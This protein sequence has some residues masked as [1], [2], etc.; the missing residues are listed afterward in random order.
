MA[1]KMFDFCI[2]NPP[3]QDETLGDNKG[4]APPVYDQF[5]DA[6][7]EISE[8]VELIHPARF[9]FN[10]GSTPKAWNKKMLSDPH[11][12]V[13]FHEQNSA[14]VFPNT[15]IMGGVAVT[16]HDNS[17]N[18]G[19]IEIYTAFDE[20]NSILKKVYHC[21]EFKSF[22]DIVISSYSYHFTKAM[23][24]DYPLAADKLSKGHQYDL[25]SNVLEKLD[26]IFLVEPPEQIEK[27]VA[28]YGRVKNERVFRYILKEYITEVSNLYKW[29]IFVPKANGSGALG[30]VVSTSVI[31][32]PIV[33]QPAVGHT[34]SFISIGS[35]ETENEAIACYKYI[36]SKFAR[37]LLGILK[38]TQ[39]N[40]PEKWKYIP[41]QIF[42]K[43]SDIDWSKSV[44]EIDLQLYRK[45][46]L[47]SEEIDFIETNVK[48]MI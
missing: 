9:L 26:N 47:S 45:Y 39:D 12:K 29:K 28:I 4:F 10:A 37:C 6:A 22:K 25:K 32:Q 2:G 40:P 14:K 11:L 36:C 33:I 34:E 13:L 20:L 31:G 1:K 42:T 3:Y 35:F 41:L 15:D 43:N 21:K 27:Y 16:Y 17:K 48:E 7:Y 30:E 46:G 23:H 8:C 24:R 44:H 5:M 18:F 19:A 38:V